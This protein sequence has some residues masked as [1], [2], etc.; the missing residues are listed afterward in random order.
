VSGGWITQADRA[1]W[2]Q[3]AARELAVI[4]EDCGGLPLLAWT[5]SPAGGSLAGQVAGAGAGAA[6]AAWRQALAMD[7][8]RETSVAAGAWVRARVW[9]GGVRVTV[10][11]T[12]CAGDRDGLIP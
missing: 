8:V 5:V 11:A 7:D 12:I 3:Q 6:F 1:G 10:T 9:R 2:Q 4:L